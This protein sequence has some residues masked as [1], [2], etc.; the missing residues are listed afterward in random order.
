[1]TNLHAALH[2]GGKWLTGEG[3]EIRTVSPSTGRELAAT[4]SAGPNQVAAAVAAAR[5]AFDDGEWSRLGP[6][7]RSALLYRLADL[8]ERDRDRLLD[9]AAHEIGSPVGNAE[10]HVDGPIAYFRWF[11]EAARRGPRDG[12]EEPLPLHHDPL[13]SASTLLREPAGV[14][15]AIT[16]YNGPL[17]LCAWKLGPALAAG[18][19]TV[20]VPSP[21]AI[22]CNSALVELVEEAG[23]PPGAV[24][25]VFG[26]PAVTEQVVQADEVDLVSFTGSPAVGGKVMA[27]AAPGLKKVVLE[28][29]GKSPNILLPGTD[30]ASV[31]APSSLRF[32]RNAGQA[33]G[34]TTRTLVP[35]KDFDE[36]VERSAEFLGNLVVG[37]PF[38]PKTAVGPLIT[39]EHHRNVSGYV[40]R[41][42]DEGATVVTGGGRPAG[43]DEGFFFAPTLI[44]GAPNTAEI[45]QEE[46][47]APVGIVLPYRDVEEAIRVANDTTYALN[48]NVWGPTPDAL[49]VARRIRS[50]TVTINGGGG[51]RTDAPWGGPGY[52]GIGREGGEEGFREFFEV[53]HVQWPL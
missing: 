30:V 8:M 36:Y 48:A 53:K 16:A 24:N 50:G 41:A 28:L 23:F 2:V 10:L 25:L 45:A 51:R 46:L 27:L 31:V 49:A 33:C 3:P 35:E 22:L 13:T 20:L 26:P 15:A 19:T 14:V 21:K 12:W 5:H 18:C 43:L 38:S 17:M 44:T 37:D 34:A 29:G 40:A 1:M 47:F 42:V 11:A 6:R 32:C 4:P 9:L 52:S 7:E 39:G